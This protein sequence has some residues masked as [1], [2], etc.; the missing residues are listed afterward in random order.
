MP[1]LFQGRIICKKCSK[2]FDWVYFESR[3]SKL[4]SVGYAFVEKLPREPMAHIIGKNENGSN[5]L[6]VLCPHCRYENT[7]S[8]DNIEESPIYR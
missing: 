8:N 7:F 2:R 5:Q 1:V 6:R 3:R 4:S